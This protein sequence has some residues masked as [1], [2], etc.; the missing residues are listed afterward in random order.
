MVLVAAGIAGVTSR[1]PEATTEPAVAPEASPGTR[2]VGIGDLVVAVPSSWVRFQPMCSS[3]SRPYVYFLPVTATGCIPTPEDS[4][5][6][7]SALG[8]GDPDHVWT[9]DGIGVKRV[10]RYGVETT[11]LRTCQG[12]ET[13]AW[14]QEVV[15]TDDPDVGFVLDFADDDSDQKAVADAI[16]DSLRR[17]PEGW[18]TVPFVDQYR[19]G[20]TSEEAVRTIEDAGLEVEGTIP[21]GRVARTSPVA[22]TV[23]ATGSKVRLVGERQVMEWPDCTVTLSM[24]GIDQEIGTSGPTPE[25]HFATPGQVSVTVGDSC[26]WD[27]G[28]AAAVVGWQGH[29]PRGRDDDCSLAL[30]ADD[31]HVVLVYQPCATT[32]SRVPG[33]TGGDHLPGRLRIVF[34]VGC[35]DVRSDERLH[36]RRRRLIPCRAG[37]CRNLPR[38]GRRHVFRPWRRTCRCRP[39]RRACPCQRHR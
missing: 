7:Q 36:F 35:L 5:P 11:V 13:G 22:G 31:T 15:R 33:A 12:N 38:H 24:N 6:R 14:C 19:G 4:P 23:V 37:P 39:R 9:P 18:T 26:P 16:A 28:V 3:P 21:R 17:L 27:L 10:S 8:I 25:L 2:L 34:R 32:S 30:S 29:V 20:R 1:S